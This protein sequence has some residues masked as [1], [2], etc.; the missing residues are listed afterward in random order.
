[1]IL[2]RSLLFI[3]TA[4]NDKLLVLLIPSGLQFYRNIG[5]F[6]SKNPLLSSIQ[7]T[8]DCKLQHLKTNLLMPDMA[9]VLSKFIVNNVRRQQT[10]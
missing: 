9:F 10:Y 5:E 6:F 4:M 1:M 2:Y 3:A 7:G 8:M